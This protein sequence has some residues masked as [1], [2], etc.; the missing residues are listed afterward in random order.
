M[1]ILISSICRY[2]C[3][4]TTYIT[5]V[6][7]KLAHTLCGHLI[8]IPKS[9]VGHDIFQ[10]VFC[11]SFPNTSFW[12]V[13]TLSYALCLFFCRLHL[14]LFYHF[15]AWYCFAT[16]CYSCNKLCICS[17]SISWWLRSKLCNI[18]QVIKLGTMAMLIF[19]FPC[20]SRKVFLRIPNEFL[21]TNLFLLCFMLY[22]FSRIICYPSLCYLL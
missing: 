7:L 12:I 13:L 20:N 1:F 3:K 8:V 6:K 22:K 16:T 10:V 19:I 2:F 11:H 5:Q 17:T 21:M 15:W 18:T 4:K 14:K 9:F